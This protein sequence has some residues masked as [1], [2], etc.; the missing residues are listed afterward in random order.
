M[1]RMFTDDQLLE[2]AEP[3]CEKALRA[4]H[5]G[6]S[7]ALNGYLNEMAVGP[8]PLDALGMP[9]IAQFVGEF[10][11]DFGEE[12]ARALLARVGRY[13]LRTFVEDWEAG[14]E[15]KVIVDLLALFKHQ[16]GAN[17][18]PVAET[19][20]EVI[21]DLAPCGSGGRF[22]LDGSIAEMPDW[23]GPWSDGA[24]AF[25]QMCKSMQRAFNEEVGLAAWTT[26][27]SGDLPGRCRLSFRKHRAKGQKLFSPA[28][29]YGN[30]KT[31]ARMA[32]EKVAAGDLDVAGLI[33]NQHL[34]WLPWHDVMVAIIGYLFETCYAERGV[35]YL[36]DKLQS[37]YNPAFAVFYPYYEA[38][39]DEQNVRLLCRVHNYHMMTFALTEEEDRFAF[40][41]DPCGSGGRLYRGQMWRDVFRYGTGEITQLIKEEHAATFYRQDFPVYCSHCSSH[42]RDQFK[43]GFLWFINDGRLQSEPGKPCAQYY[44]KKSKGIRTA[45]VEPDLR[46]QVGM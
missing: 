44:Y 16:T 36:D 6:D 2:M 39:N 33:E 41:L 30:A 31:R 46:A 28:D 35:Q 5:A 42:N 19:G 34:D 37:A 29:L 13:L 40:K 8:A 14:K 15:E 3:P 7:I 27:I 43:R 24:P 23:Y 11:K 25:C 20:D 32:V 21:Y 22:M 45:Q 18:V 38:L 26:E 12:K 4:L 1:G 17:V 10:R 9:I